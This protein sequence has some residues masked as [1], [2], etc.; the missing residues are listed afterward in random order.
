MIRELLTDNPTINLLKRGL[1]ATSLR[2][3]VISDNI[4]N[5]G[6]PDHRSREVHFESLFTKALD[7]KVKSTRTDPD[8]RSID[9]HQQLPRPEVIDRESDRDAAAALEE[10]MVA[11]IENSTKHRAL[12][13]LLN[14]NYKAIVTAIRGRSV[15]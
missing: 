7:A 11:L 15:D 5:A 2:H 9:L 8:H 3:R 14:G 13:R 12:L 6:V 10:E 1:E 4:V